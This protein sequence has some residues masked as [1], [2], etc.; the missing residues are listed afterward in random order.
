MKFL[1]TGGLGFIGSHLTDY[2]IKKGHEVVIVDNNPSSN[3]K[4]ESG[5]KIFIGDAGN[6][7][8]INKAILGCDQVFHL[9]ARL[10]VE[11]VMNSGSSL[12]I[13]EAN[14]IKTLTDACIRNDIKKIIFTSSSEVYA[15]CKEFPLKE[16]DAKPIS[17]YAISKFFIEKYLTELSREKTLEY[18]ILRYFNVYGP[19]QK[20]DFVVS[21]FISN[22]IADK[23]INVYD[24]GE[25][26]RD[27]TFIDDAVKMTFES[28][29][30]RNKILNV[31][32][33]KETKL[34]DLAEMISSIH[35]TRINI[36]DGNPRNSDYN[37][38][39]RVA[40]ITKMKSL[41]GH[42]PETSLEQGIKITYDWMKN[43]SK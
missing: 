11:N 38:L 25:S 2:L 42:T 4:N 23:Q 33:G 7:E 8:V 3:Y 30:L 43:S 5:A 10:G 26:T 28:A 20:K 37:A 1:V 18:V 41:L 39:R 13:D 24:S 32:T 17:A 36:V 14:I 40:D 19:R 6:P 34:I 35:K 27:Y 21:K 12:L 16:N 22:S 29:K 15:G 31:G 9:A